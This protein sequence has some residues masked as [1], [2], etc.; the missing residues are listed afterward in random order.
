[1]RLRQQT[2]QRKG[3][4]HDSPA[5]D[6]TAPLPVS[7]RSSQGCLVVSTHRDLKTEAEIWNRN[8]G[9]GMVSCPAN[10]PPIGPL[11]DG[12]PPPSSAAARRGAAALRRKRA[13]CATA[14]QGPT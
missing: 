1:M 11:R 2:A 7:L 6:G 8:W 5:A 9:A 10:V 4:A 13:D 3:A 12:T 14:W